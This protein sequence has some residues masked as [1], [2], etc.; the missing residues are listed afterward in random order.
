MDGLHFDI[1]L[2]S[3]SPTPSITPGKVVAGITSTHKRIRLTTPS[4]SERNK[5]L[6]SRRCSRER[7]DDE[8]GTDVSG[9]HDFCGINEHISLIHIFV[10]IVCTR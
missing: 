8:D 7:I 6:K 2:P 4:N 9:S 10:Y 3:P 1:G 5:N